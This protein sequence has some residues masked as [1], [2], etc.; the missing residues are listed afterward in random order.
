MELFTKFPMVSNKLRT[1]EQVHHFNIVAY[2]F[3]L[4]STPTETT[5]LLRHKNLNSFTSLGHTHTHQHVPP[6]NPPQN[7]IGISNEDEV[8]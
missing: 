2:L 6:P 8:A 4:F 3:C 1:N 7:H 5:N